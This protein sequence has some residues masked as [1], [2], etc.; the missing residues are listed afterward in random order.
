MIEDEAIASQ[1][2]ALL[3]PA[4]TSQEN[5]YRQLGMRQ[6]ILTLPLMVAAVLTLLW[7][8][9]AGVTELTRMLAREGGLWCDRLKVSQ[10]A[11]SQRFLTFPASLFE[12]VIDLMHLVSLLLVLALCLVAFSRSS[13][14]APEGK[15]KG[16]GQRAKG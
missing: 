11:L 16:K 15:A 14:A 5:Y 9:V 12:I 1:L 7:R 8:D 6:R 10:Q 2:E 4:I 3:T 13:E